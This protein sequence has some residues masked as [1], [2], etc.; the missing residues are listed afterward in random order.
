MLIPRNCVAVHKSYSVLY[1]A[2]L[3]PPRAHDP[4]IVYTSVPNL[5]SRELLTQSLSTCSEGIVS[6][7]GGR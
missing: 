3:P 5:S 7:S 2:K 1:R 6:L 4:F